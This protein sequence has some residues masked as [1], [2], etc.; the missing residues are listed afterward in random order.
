M[1]NCRICKE[2]S[3]PGDI[4]H[5]NL[6]I[7]GSE[8]VDVCFNCEMLIVEFIRALKSV[9]GESYIRGHKDEK[10]GRKEV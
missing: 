6:F 7:V 5:L 8:G 10:R 1:M 2:E 9:A 4:K 3:E